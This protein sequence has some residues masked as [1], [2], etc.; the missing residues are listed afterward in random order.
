M[1]SGLSLC[2]VLKEEKIL[3]TG[4]LQDGHLVSSGALSGRWSVKW[5]PQALHSPSHNSYSYNGM[6]WL[7]SC[8]DGKMSNQIRN[9]IELVI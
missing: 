2:G 9:D 5:P 1:E 8:V 7:I 3:R 6:A 4:F